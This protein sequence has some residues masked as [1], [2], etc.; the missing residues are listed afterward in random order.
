MTNAF[1]NPTPSPYEN[2]TIAPPK[3]INKPAPPTLS[4]EKKPPV[5]RNSI[6]LMNEPGQ[7]SVYQQSGFQ[8]SVFNKTLEQDKK[9]GGGSA[10]TQSP[11]NVLPYYERSGLMFNPNW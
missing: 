5:E 4:F 7:G 6:R 8:N 2:P 10:Y 9:Y 11:A 3:V 1:S